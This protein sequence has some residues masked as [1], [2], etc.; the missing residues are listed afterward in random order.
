MPDTG[1]LS[2]ATVVN[3]GIG[4]EP[5]TNPMDAAA[6]GAGV[7]ASCV[8]PAFP[9]DVFSDLLRATDY[10]GTVPVGATVDG[11]RVDVDRHKSLPASLT[12][13]EV[14]FL[15]AGA[16][17][18]LNLALPGEWP[19]LDAVQSYGGPN[20]LGGVAWTVAEANTQFGF[21]I[22]FTTPAGLQGGFIEC[23]P[24][25]IFFTLASGA[26]GWLLRGCD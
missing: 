3:V 17:V 24:V 8:F 20:E 26:K 14:F 13:L 22:S 1:P 5:W 9:P 2:P 23:F 7:Y 10:A 18:G 16:R 6:C 21:E 11:F 12:D 25:T 15:K 4:G 19:L